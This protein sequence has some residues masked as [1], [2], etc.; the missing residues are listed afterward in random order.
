MFIYND[1]GI[2]IYG[3]KV[4]IID[5][6]LFLTVKKENIKSVDL[7]RNKI[8]LL[9]KDLNVIDMEQ[10]KLSGASGITVV[11]DKIKFFVK[12]NETTQKVYDNIKGL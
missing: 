10:L 1:D 2:N 5:F 4:S 7:I 11:G 3:P 9:V 12:D 6:D 8:V